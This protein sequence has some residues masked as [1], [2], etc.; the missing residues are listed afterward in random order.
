M[1]MPV[2]NKVETWHLLSYHLR[3]ILVILR[4]DDATIVATM[5]KANDEVGMLTF[6]NNLH[7]LTSRTN[8][9]LKSKSRP[10]F[11]G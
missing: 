11:L 5:E 9:L 4:G 3:C 7:P 2:A 1:V 10:H 6:L 8:H